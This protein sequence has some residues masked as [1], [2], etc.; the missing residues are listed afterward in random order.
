MQIRPYDPA[1]HVPPLTDQI[2]RDYGPA[3]EV[4]DGPFYVVITL[5]EILGYELG[6]GEPSKAREAAVNHLRA[7]LQEALAAGLHPE[8]LPRDESAPSSA[9]DHARRL[10]ATSLDLVV[11]HGP[12][13]DELSA[14]AYAIDRASWVAVM[15][16]KRVAGD[17]SELDRT[18]AKIH[19]DL[20]DLFSIA[21]DRTTPSQPATRF[22]SVQT[23]RC[24][25]YEG[26]PRAGYTGFIERIGSGAPEGP[27]RIVYWLAADGEVQVPAEP[28]LPPDADSPGV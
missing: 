1:V 27:E 10:V 5:G 24:H 25:L 16:R 26:G 8:C 15:E 28:G 11:R 12:G 21:R 9:A 23:L 14:L 20:R 6:L 3:F 18:Y 2:L 17:R 7:R 22:E 4:H 13:R 19:S